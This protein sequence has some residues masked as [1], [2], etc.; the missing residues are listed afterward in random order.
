MSDYTQISWV[1]DYSEANV[2]INGEHLHNHVWRSAVPYAEKT[3][4]LSP[5][6]I[7]A[8]NANTVTVK[9]LKVTETPF[10]PSGLNRLLEVTE[11]LNQKL[12]S[13]SVLVMNLPKCK[14]ITSG[15]QRWD[16]LFKE[17]NFDSWVKENTHLHKEFFGGTPVFFFDKDLNF[18]HD[19]PSMNLTVHDNVT[20]ADA[21]PYKLIDF[22]G[23]LYA[24]LHYPLDSTSDHDEMYRLII[25]WLQGTGF[26]YDETCYF[27]AQEIYGTC[28]EIEKGLGCHQFLRCVPIKLR[29]E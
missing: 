27:I 18:L 26:E 23:G 24:A 5:V 15:W 8:G 17:G 9:S 20:A 6:D 22:E 13:E 29:K 3:K 2:Y 25:E 28:K 1:L 4:V 16:D 10:T 21:A 7:T 19:N 11:K 12:H 14:I